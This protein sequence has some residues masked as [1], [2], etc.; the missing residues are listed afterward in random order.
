MAFGG[1]QGGG[2]VG[3][4]LLALGHLEKVDA[5]GLLARGQ[6]VRGKSPSA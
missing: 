6:V 3:P 1:S 2:G 4:G 5:S